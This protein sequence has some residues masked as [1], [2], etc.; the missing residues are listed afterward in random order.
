MHQIL[1]NK[2]KRYHSSIVYKL[3]D[4]LPIV[5]SS[6]WFLNFWEYVDHHHLQFFMNRHRS[7]P[8]IVTEDNNV[9]L[10]S[11]ES[12][13]FCTNVKIFIQIY[14]AFGG[15]KIK[16]PNFYDLTFNIS[17]INRRV[18][19]VN[20]HIFMENLQDIFRFIT[21]KARSS[22]IEHQFRQISPHI[23]HSLKG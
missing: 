18:S 10:I 20:E 13:L 22:S 6:T 23:I 9:C 5:P 1:E 8:L 16:I 11:A 12:L 15:H 21:T 19:G 3:E 14:L 4:L 2:F 7:I 17:Q